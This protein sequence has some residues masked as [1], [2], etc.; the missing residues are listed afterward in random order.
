VKYSISLF[1]IVGLLSTTF[2]SKANASITIDTNKLLNNPSVSNI[3]TKSVVEEE[4]P[5]SY[6]ATGKI[7]TEP[8]QTPGRRFD[9]VFFISIPVT[10][11]LLLNIMQL[12]NMYFANSTPLD[13]VDWTYIYLN[14]FILP[15]AVAYFDYS[16]MEQQRRIK[17]E[18]AWNGHR[19]FF[20]VQLPVYSIRF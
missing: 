18:L 16:Y 6:L 9:V 2:L 15:L 1:L 7:Q 5:N 14:T 13:G 8:P 10:Y 4:L 20:N 3:V 11:Y 19:D 17:E 12:K